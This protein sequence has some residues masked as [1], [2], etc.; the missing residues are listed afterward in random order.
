MNT[1]LIR[2]DMLDKRRINIYFIQEFV[3]SSVSM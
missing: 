3:V 2:L 1:I